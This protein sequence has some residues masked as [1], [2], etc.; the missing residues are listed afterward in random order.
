M[1]LGVKFDIEIMSLEYPIRT[2]LLFIRTFLLFYSYLFTV[3]RT[4]FLL[5]CVIDYF[6]SAG[7][8]K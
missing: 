1:F 4:L 5:T 8:R 2:F 6:F 3:L 7:E